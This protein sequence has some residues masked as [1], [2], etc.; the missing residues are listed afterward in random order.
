[1]FYFQIPGIT[2]VGHIVWFPNEYLLQKLPNMAKALDKKAQLAVNQ[3]RAQW[4]Q[5]KAQ[6]LTK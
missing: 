5:A 1:M 3:A 4:L 2:L 6:I